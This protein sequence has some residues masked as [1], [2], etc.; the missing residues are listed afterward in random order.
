MQLSDA[1]PTSPK[2]IT[3]SSSSGCCFSW[4]SFLLCYLRDIQ[5]NL[6]SGC[7]LN[8][9]IPPSIRFP[10]IFVYAAP[11]LHARVGLPTS[12]TLLT[13]FFVCLIAF[14][15]FTPGWVVTSQPAILIIQSICFHFGLLTLFHHLQGVPVPLNEKATASISWPLIS[16]TYERL[17]LVNF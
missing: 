10:I 12:Q 17:D 16:L 2:T 6:R 11:P 3:S 9:T 7:F 13:H 14:F 15:A 4:S 5:H 8:G 1:A